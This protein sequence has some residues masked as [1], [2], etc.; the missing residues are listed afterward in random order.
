LAGRAAFDVALHYSDSLLVLEAEPNREHIARDAVSIVRRIMSRLSSQS[1]LDEFHRDAATQIRAMTDFERLMIYRFAPGGEGEVISESLADGM[2]SFLGLHYP[3]SGIPVQAR[4]LYLRN[5]FR[6]IADVDAETVVLL[7][8]SGLVQ[9]LDLSLAMTRA[10]SPTHVEYLPTP[11]RWRV[12]DLLLD[13]RRQ[14]VWRDGCEIPLPK[15][16]YDLLVTL[17]RYHPTVISDERLMKDVWPGLVV[18]QETI[19]QRVKLL[20]DA[21]GDDSRNPRYITRLRSRGY[22]LIGPVESLS[23]G[24]DLPPPAA[25]AEVQA[26]ITA[27]EELSLLEPEWRVEECDRPEWAVTQVIAKAVTAEMFSSLVAPA[28]VSEP[29]RCEHSSDFKAKAA[30]EALKG[31]KTIA[32]IAA[33]YEVHANQISSWKTQLLENAAGIFGVGIADRAG[34]PLDSDVSNVPRRSPHEDST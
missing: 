6:I 21:L 2:E 16:T 11:S 29:A 12:S 20:R 3:A 4:A 18:S 26:P 24:D 17:A 31:E 15:L 7:P 30:L 10:V 13:T 32:Q 5:P 22:H 1:T 8:G 28:S 34:N 19:S 27:E 25:T 23:D 33:T 14:R 9:S